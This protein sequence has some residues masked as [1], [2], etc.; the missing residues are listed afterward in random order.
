MKKKGKELKKKKKKKKE[1]SSF[2]L[3][4][5]PESVKFSEAVSF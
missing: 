5:K 4:N 1:T 2:Q 3:Q